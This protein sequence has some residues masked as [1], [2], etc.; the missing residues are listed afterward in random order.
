MKSIDDLAKAKEC[1]YRLLKYRERSTKEIKDRLKEKGFSGD[2]CDRVID[3]LNRLGYLDDKRFAN[4]L[5]DSIIKFR[6]GGLAL[7]RSA[8]YAKGVPAKI[9]D[10][11]IT[12]VK[13][14]YDEY[15]AAYALASGRVKRFKN[16]EP[17]RAKQRIYNFL[18]RRRFKQET[19]LEVLNQI[20]K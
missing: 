9:I 18:L 8:L 4:M 6:P 5:A 15:E 7:V 14:G 20:F 19:I 1:A 13:D 2:I 17:E 10:S 11:V 3:E 16:I 12:D